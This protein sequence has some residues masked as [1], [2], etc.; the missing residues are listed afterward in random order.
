M[1]SHRLSPPYVECVTVLLTLLSTALTPVVLQEPAQLCHDDRKPIACPLPCYCGAP[2]YRSVRCDAGGL[3]SV[4][5][6]VWSVV[7]LSLNFSFNNVAEWTHI[8]VAS[9]DDEHVACL[10]TLILDHSGIVRLRPRA[11]ER[12]RGLRQL[13][14]HHNR[15]STLQ[16]AAFVGLR[17]LELLDLSHNELVALPRSLFDELSQLKV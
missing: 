14:L 10:G 4:P 8:D 2:D 13:R 5:A 16:T 7:P 12:L 11:F 17:R 15:I 9:A 6:S 3:R 1:T